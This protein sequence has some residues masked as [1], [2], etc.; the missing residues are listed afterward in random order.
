M[1]KMPETEAV[2]FFLI[3]AILVLIALYVL[4]GC[5]AFDVRYCKACWTDGHAYGTAC[6][7]KCLDD[8]EKPVQDCRNYCD[9]EEQK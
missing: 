8:L 7:E 1:Q 9:S 5:A 2:K 6:M 3:N 4:I